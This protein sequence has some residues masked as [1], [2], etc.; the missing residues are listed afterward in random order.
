MPPLLVNEETLLDRSHDTVVEILWHD[1]TF[2][3]PHVTGLQGHVRQACV[4]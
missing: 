4:T 1:C 3:G 2:R